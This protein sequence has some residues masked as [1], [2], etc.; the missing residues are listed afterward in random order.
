MGPQGGS[1][2]LQVEFNYHMDIMVSL[3]NVKL[4]T[5]APFSLILLQMSGIDFFK[6]NNI[7]LCLYL[8]YTFFLVF[9]QWTPWLIPNL[10][11]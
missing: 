8:H 7:T 2:C 4:D 9:C 1:W 6:L 5:S 3:S 11:Y 10:G